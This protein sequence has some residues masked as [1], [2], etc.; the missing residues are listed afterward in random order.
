MVLDILTLLTVRS[1]LVGDSE[2]LHIDGIQDSTT[3]EV[4]VQLQ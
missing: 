4:S 1:V 2:V 3:E